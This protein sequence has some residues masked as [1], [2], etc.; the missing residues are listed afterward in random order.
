MV[1]AW[2]PV[3]PRPASESPERPGL[4]PLGAAGPRRPPEDSKPR[5]LHSAY[6]AKPF[7]CRD[8]KVVCSVNVRGTG[9]LWQ[10]QS[11][12]LL[13]LPHFRGLTEMQRGARPPP[14][15]PRVGLLPP[16]PA[17][18]AGV[19]CRAGEL[20]P[21][22]PRTYSALGSAIKA[23]LEA[24]LWTGP[25]PLHCCQYRPKVEF[26]MIVVRTKH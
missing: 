25:L 12:N 22:L 7:P 15:C 11:G 9:A 18:S 2:P 20:P 1:T 19:S 13:A 14:R 8:D 26:R 23:A 4:R 16:P 5:F 21:H 24:M 6:A 3:A 10:P 17:T